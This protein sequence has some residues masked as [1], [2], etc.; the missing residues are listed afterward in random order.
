MALV[1]GLGHPV[2]SRALEERLVGVGGRRNDG[3]DP[4]R[5]LGKVGPGAA[6]AIQS[7]RGQ[8]AVARPLSLRLGH[9]TAQSPGQQCL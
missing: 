7:R 6:G 1:H 3:V 5:E 2:D 8:G 9:D 4:V